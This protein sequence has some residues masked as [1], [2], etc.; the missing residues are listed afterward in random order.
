MLNNDLM[1]P[2]VASN[3]FGLTYAVLRCNEHTT[4]D[5][6]GSGI[7]VKNEK[8]DFFGST[9]A[10]NVNVSPWTVDTAN[11]RLRCDIVLLPVWLSTAGQSQ[12]RKHSRRKRL[13]PSEPTSADPGSRGTDCDQ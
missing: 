4:L 8:E 12:Y 3:V 13:E 7:L 11:P 2:Q 9:N 10:A 5:D 6:F 1:T